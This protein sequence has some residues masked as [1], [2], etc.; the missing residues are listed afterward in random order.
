MTE[1]QQAADFNFASPEVG[2]CPYPFYDAARAEAAVCPVP[3]VGSHIV[4]S[5]DDVLEAARTPEIFS[6]HRPRFGA[7]NPELEAIAA[8]GYPS[9]AALVTSDPPEHTRYRK[10][11]NGP[12]TPGAVS[13]HEPLIREVVSGLIDA[14]IDDGEAE[15]MSQFA[16]P[17][18][19]RVTGV[20]LGVPTED[21]SNFGRWADNIAESVSGYLPHER[22]VECARGLVELQHYFADLVEQRRKDPQDDLIS[23]MVTYSENERPLDLPEILELIRI[24]VAGGTESTAGLV[25]SAFYLLLKHPDQFAEVRED[26][27][28][29]PQMLE[30][31]LR[32]E[33][34][35]QWNPRMVEKEGVEWK[36]ASLAPGSRVLLSWGA[37][38]RDQSKFGEDADQFDIHRR[39]GP[40]AAFGHAYH[41]CLGAPLARL[42]ARIACE[43]LIKRLDQLQ[44][45]VSPDEVTFVGH[46]VVRRI[47]RLPVKFSPPSGSTGEAA[48]GP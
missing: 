9:S 18:P 40:H 37:A 23:H 33:S 47:E 34:P 38:N 43:E 45:A 2:S 3:S 6:S 7:G 41:L 4:T 36:G 19:T 17:F 42:E 11:V 13:K 28:L 48:T 29:I 1:L 24:L 8:T 12:F 46:G 10:L 20:I 16:L 14:F 22:A 32:L 15:L 31:V 5:F 39:G 25:T 27:S 30:E 44:L 21:Q 35:V 26:H